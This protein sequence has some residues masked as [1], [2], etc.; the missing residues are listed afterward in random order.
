MT[1]SAEPERDRLAVLVHEVRSPV[2]ALS[3]IAEVYREADRYARR[4]L[5]GLALA[6][7]SGIDRLLTDLQPASVVR[8][9]LDL[10]HVVQQSVAAAAL[11]GASIRTEIEPRLPR[12]SADPNRIRQAVDNLLQNALTH[13]RDGEVVVGVRAVGTTVVVSVS[14]SGP[15]IPREEQARIFDAGVRLDEACPGSGLGLAIVRAIA[16]AHGGTVG[17]ES[18]PGRGATF[19]LALPVG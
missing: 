1:I 17:V 12:V 2:A 4:S 7:C 14:D 11:R 18:V 19:T 15:G 16:E 10:G 8:G 6:A 3:A 5:V 13:A 9:S